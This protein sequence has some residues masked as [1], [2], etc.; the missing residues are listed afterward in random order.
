MTPTPCIVV[1]FII[2]IR[3]TYSCAGAL[4]YLLNYLLTQLAWGI[5]PKRLTIERNLQLTA[6]IK[7]YTGFRLPPKFMTLNDLR[8]KFKVIDSTNT[9][10]QWLRCNIKWLE[11]LSLLGLRIH[12]P[13]H[14]LTY[15]ITY[16]QYTDLPLFVVS[17]LWSSFLT[18]QQMICLPFHCLW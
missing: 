16:L 12:A 1:G 11:A 13:M 10:Y 3:P 18:F 14:L 4:T 9:A 2:S 17:G 8:A 15:L 7:S 6:Y 5:S